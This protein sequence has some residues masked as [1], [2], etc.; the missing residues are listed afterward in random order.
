MTARSLR[1]LFREPIWFV[2]LG[3]AVLGAI[4]GNTLAHEPGTD[5][6]RTVIGRAWRGDPSETRAVLGAL[7]GFQVTMVAM[8]FSLNAVVM[9]SAAYQYSPRLIPL[10][11]KNAPIRRELP[12]LVLLAA[13]LLA[14]TRELGLVADDGERPRGV[15]SVAVLLLFIAVTFLLLDLVRTF[16]FVRVERVLGLVRDATFAAAKRIRA[17]VE[18]LP[19]DGSSPLAL[20]LDASALV[21]RESGYLVDV[22]L[23]RL[24]RLAKRA[25]V[26]TRI[27]RAIGEYV[28][29][30]EV[31][32]WVAADDGRGVDPRLAQKFARTL[33]I[34]AVRELDY[35]PLLGIRIIVDVANRSLSSSLNDPYT[36]RQA[37][38]QLR[39][40]LRHVGRLPLGDWNVIDDEDGSV[41][42]SVTST[43]LRELLAVAVSGPL[44]YGAEHPDVLEGLLEIVL[45]VG[46]VARD[47]EDRA[48]ARTLL[49]RIE[50]LA[51]QCDLDPERLERLR[52]ES[53]PVRRSLE[54]APYPP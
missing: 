48:A 26:R 6:A 28:D 37:L 11:I 15:V 46:W 44:H 38:N 17:R 9:K 1:K 7:L 50:N 3:A 22:D 13:Y 53:A 29:E 10:Y 33:V 54:M 16:R 8:L 40:V 12:L 19:L 14:A 49:D 35:D 30:D 21:A 52:S 45:E 51:E 36:A 23:Q 42:V 20:P 41:R 25:G 31:I 18:R 34:S 47:P 32:G 2:L 39:S 27:S 5:A 43:H 24:T 4:L